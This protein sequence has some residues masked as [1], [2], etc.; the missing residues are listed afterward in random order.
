[1]RK[2]LSKGGPNE[3]PTEHE[4]PLLTSARVLYRARS[5]IKTI[6]ALGLEARKKNAES[7]T[8]KLIGCFY[9]QHDVNQSI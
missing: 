3:F 5:R 1:M 9:A 2:L 7:G 6:H 8:G 4:A